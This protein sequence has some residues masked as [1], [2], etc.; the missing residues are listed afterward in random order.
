MGLSTYAY[1]GLENLDCLFDECG[2]PVDPVTREPYE[3]YVQLYR[4]PDFPEQ[5]DDLK[6]MGWYLYK[7]SDHF[8]STSYSGYN[9]W[10]E[11]LAKLAGYE[12]VWYESVPGYAP[13][14][15]L[16]HQVGAFGVDSGAFHELICFSDC[17]GTIGA[18]TS[19]KL[20][21]DFA[22]FDEKAKALGDDRFYKG[23]E[24]FKECFE[25][26]SDNGAVK[27]T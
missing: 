23:Y 9:W 17:E 4:S 11:T 3:N 21:K 25:F 19:A 16:S 26:A 27:F 12:P 1:K 22:E 15:K 13:S 10:R 24:L 20:A 6:E 2:E 5:A 7:D 8:Y 18:K 14:K